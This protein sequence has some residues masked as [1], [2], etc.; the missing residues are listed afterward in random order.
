M[1]TLPIRVRHIFLDVDGT[2]LDFPASLRA[3]TAAAAAYL[4]ERTGRPISP[5]AVHEAVRRLASNGRGGHGETRLRAFRQMLRERG[6]DDE[7]AAL[8]ALQRD[9]DARAAAL[10]IYDDVL[11]VMV[12]LRERG[13]VLVAATNGQPALEQTPLHPLLHY[14]W[15]AAD[16]SVSKP[17]PDF[18]LRALAH[19]GASP[20]SSLMVGDRLDNDIEPAHS[21]GMPTILLDRYRDH[22]ELPPPALALIHSLAELP[23]LVELLDGDG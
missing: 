8:E 1:S 3:G 16:A 22:D 7:S 20:A 4:A 6:V 19:V 18:F 21:V 15:K 17:H 11:D 12:E 2:L 13:F 10:T 9:H 14:A 5:E 23:G